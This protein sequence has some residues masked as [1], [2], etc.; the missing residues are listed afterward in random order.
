MLYNHHE[1]SFYEDSMDRAGNPFGDGYPRI[2]SLN[3][4]IPRNIG[5][6]EPG[7]NRLAGA[8]YV[9]DIWIHDNDMLIGGSI[10]TLPDYSI[11]N[12]QISGCSNFISV[13][14]LQ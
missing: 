9:G 3:V 12:K 6:W 7:S 4:V 1:R 14:F 11:H 2:G 13:F 5:H 8:E 10:S